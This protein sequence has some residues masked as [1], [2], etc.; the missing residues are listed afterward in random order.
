MQPQHQGPCNR[1]LPFTF[2][3][4]SDKQSQ[5]LPRVLH[6]LLIIIIP[7]A[8]ERSFVKTC[9]VWCQLTGAGAGLLAQCHLAAS[10]CVLECLGHSQKKPPNLLSS[11]L[12][13]FVSSLTQS[14]SPRREEKKNNPASKLLLL[15]LSCL[16]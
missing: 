1:L 9:A 12:I 6:A 7:E 14:I 2:K 8:P 16:F 5:K 13:A 3:T 4:I 10:S 15:E 11:D